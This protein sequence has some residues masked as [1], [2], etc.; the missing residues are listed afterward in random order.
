MLRS[1]SSSC[2]K[3]GSKINAIATNNKEGD[4]LLL[5]TPQDFVNATQAYRAG[6]AIPNSRLWM[7]MVDA[8][9]EYCRG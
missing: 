8:V 2:G 4:L 5:M 1:K 6:K 7:F 9:F 3:R